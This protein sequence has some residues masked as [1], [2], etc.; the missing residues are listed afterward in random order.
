MAE[1]KFLTELEPGKVASSALSLLKYQL[2][3]G[4][5]VHRDAEG[6]FHGGIG[7][8]VNVRKP[9]GADDA[10]DL[11]MDG[12]TDAT[13][14][15]VTEAHVPVVLNKQPAHTVKLTAKEASL[16]L[17]S[18]SQQVLMPQTAKMGEK[19]ERYIG[20]EMDKQL[21][22]AAGRTELSAK[23]V[24]NSVIDAR[25]KLTRANV[26]AAGRVLVCD[27]E[28]YAELLKDELFIKV[29]ESGSSEA[30]RNAMV[31]RILGFDV[32]ESNIIGTSLKSGD[33]VANGCAI[34]MSR[35]AFALAVRVPNAAQGGASSA[36]ASEQG[37]GLRWVRDFDMKTRSDLS[38]LDAFAGTATLDAK[39]AVGIAF[40]PAATV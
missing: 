28:F 27:P 10:E 33:A 25:T 36:S 40:K 18:F 20:I 16:D 29:N 34:A 38:G 11:A 23:A 14:Q 8:T 32:Y 26:P 3:L 35:D 39:R 17:V 1:Q 7:T 2:V 24:R 30:L 4:R 37:F 31:G 22:K 5:L 19:I 13:I 9:M 12:G 6:D 21:P 15:K